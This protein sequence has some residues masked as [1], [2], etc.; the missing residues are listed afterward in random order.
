MIPGAAY[1][2]IRNGTSWSQQA[3]LSTSDGSDCDYFGFSVS[4]D[5]NTACIGAFGK[6]D[7]GLNS[8]S[9]YIFNRIN[10][11]WVEEQKLFPQDSGED[12][13]FGW[14]VAI[15]NDTV[16]IGSRSDQQNGPDSGSAYVFTRTGITWTQQAKL[17]ASDGNAGDVFSWSVALDKDTA[18]ISA[19]H[20]DH[21]RGSTYLF[22]RTG[23]TWREKAKLLASDGAEMDD[24]GMC[25]SLEGDTVFIGAH[26]D[27]DNLGSV[28]VFKKESGIPNLEIGIKG[29]LAINAII[30]NHGK[31][32]AYGVEWEIQVKGGLLGLINKT[33]NGIIDIQPGESRTM[34]THLFFGLGTITV[35]VKAADMKKSA[36]GKQ[37]FFVSIIK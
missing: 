32:K 6:D 30:T 9:A 1:V 26:G 13:Y 29:G 14:S 33:E 20:Y 25:V 16:L 24:F 19:N 2:F 4:L 7:H 8:G 31:T 3:K 11:T 18:L 35:D 23:T 12:D 28:Y 27:G 15:K 10:N 37:I 5:G 22:T 36:E 21:W 17:L 34:K